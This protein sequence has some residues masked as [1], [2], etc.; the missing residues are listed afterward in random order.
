MENET[1]IFLMGIA[2]GWMIAAAFWLSSKGGQ[3]E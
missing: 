1:M 3:D 2:G